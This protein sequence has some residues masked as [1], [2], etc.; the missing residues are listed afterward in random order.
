MLFSIQSA[1]AGLGWRALIG[2]VVCSTGL[3]QTLPTL[4]AAQVAQILR[5]GTTPYALVARPL[6]VTM[7]RVDLVTLNPAT[8][9]PVAR[10]EVGSIRCARLHAAATGE[11]LCLSNNVL[12][13]GRFEFSSPYAATYSRDLSREQNHVNEPSSARI[14][15]ARISVDGKQQAWTYFIRGHN[16]MDAGSASFSTLTQINVQTD[17]QKTGVHNLEKWSLT[18]KG[19]A[20]KAVDLNYWGVSFHP[21]NSN[22]FLVTAFFKGKAYLAQG[23]VRA[24]TMTVIAQDVECPSYNPAGDTIA[25]KKRLST[26]R[27]APATL[28]LSTM[29]TTVFTH[30]KQSVDDQIDWLNDHTM[31][32]EIIDVPLLGEASI[33]LMMLDTLGKNKPH[34]VW[35][36]NARS[37]AIYLPK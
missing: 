4:D 26:T 12:T 20:V 32:Y 25:F 36:K 14:N 8:R 21:K 18:H 24:K 16:Y 34:S 33:D 35:L 13:K 15:R 1:S 28:N 29:K 6:D 27:W 9:Q 2:M 17:A 22:T 30:I 23:D 31:L 11:V 5:T 10:G 7:Q 37:A 19:A 3:A